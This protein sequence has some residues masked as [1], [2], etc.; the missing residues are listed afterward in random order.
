MCWH[1]IV[2]LFYSNFLKAVHLLIWKDMERAIT[3]DL[4]S[5]VLLF[6]DHLLK[7]IN[8]AAELDWYESSSY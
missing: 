3:R 2:Y 7:A 5:H 8:F 1:I 6:S 4:V